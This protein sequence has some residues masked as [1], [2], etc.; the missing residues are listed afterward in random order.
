[1]EPKAYY[2]HHKN[3]P[4]NTSKARLIHS[5]A[6]HVISLIQSTHI[7]IILPFMPRFPQWFLSFTFTNKYFVCSFVSPTN[8]TCPTLLDLDYT[9]DTMY[10]NPETYENCN[11]W[12][13]HKCIR[14]RWNNN[15]HKTKTS[16]F[17]C[18]SIEEKPVPFTC[19]RMY[20]DT[21]GLHGRERVREGGYARC[22]HWKH[23]ST[24]IF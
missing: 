12:E 14:G 6:V 11:M 19:P 8:A 13:I 7:S 18:G 5:I 20:R 22:Y 2:C 9:N 1:M 10:L 4:L 3:L 23:A 24:L 16:C 21:E 17:C 15:K